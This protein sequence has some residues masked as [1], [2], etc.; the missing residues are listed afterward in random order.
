MELPPTLV[1]GGAAEEGA[2]TEESG[3]STEDDEGYIDARCPLP[4]DMHQL[5]QDHAPGLLT[6]ATRAILEYEAGLRI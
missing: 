6:M 3:V 1:T 4:G 2:E 5:L